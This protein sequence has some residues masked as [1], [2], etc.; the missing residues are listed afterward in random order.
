[1]E[2]VV[3]IIGGVLSYVLL[4][5]VIHRAVRNAI[6]DAHT[7]NAHIVDNDEDNEISKIPCPNC[8]KTHDMDDPK[9]P[10]C[11]YPYM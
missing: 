9:C 8:G 5:F 4:Y 7:M 1:M 10:F 6:I 11:K 3:W 2:I